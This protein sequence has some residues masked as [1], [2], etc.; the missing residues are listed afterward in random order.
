MKRSTLAFTIAC[1][2]GAICLCGTCNE[3]EKTTE[4]TK[5]EVADT[6]PVFTNTTPSSPVLNEASI[7]A[8]KQIAENRK[9][10]D[11][12]SGDDP[13]RVMSVEEMSEIASSIKW[14]LHDAS[15]DFNGEKLGDVMWHSHVA[16]QAYHEDDKVVI[17]PILVHMSYFQFAEIRITSSADGEYSGEIIPAKDSSHY[18]QGWPGVTFDANESYLAETVVTMMEVAQESITETIQQNRGRTIWI[19]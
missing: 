5:P 7:N 8:R 17:M 3:G 12:D 9:E 16:Y 2:I 4:N 6:E 1:G 18:L 13:R 14:A 15:P 11:L 19:P 10:D